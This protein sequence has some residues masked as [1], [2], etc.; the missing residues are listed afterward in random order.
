MTGH[1]RGVWM[2]GASAVT[3]S[4][5]LVL[6]AALLVGCGSSSSSSNG[7]ASKPPAEILAAARAAGVGAA[8]VHVAGSILKAGE[9]ISLDMELVADKGGAGRL[10][11]GGLGLRLVDVDRA[12]YI[13]GSIAFYRHFVGTLA[14]KLLAGKW[15]KGPAASGPLASFAALTDL[16][17]LIDSALGGH[18]ALS[19][20]PSKV[21]DG[22][23]VLGVADRAGGG[24]LYV[25]ATG[26]PYP[27]AIIEVGTHGGTVTFN[28]WNKPVSLAVP[29][30]S[31][32]IHQLRGGR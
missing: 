11:L 23:E 29:A 18:R 1:P 5:A 20:A 19:R 13:K 7:L 28:R 6:L 32:S 10:T 12:V 3:R 26:T 31:I 27:V 14:A 16:R 25:A 4:L 17:T 22:R 30:T 24:T 21:I 8:T 2:P 15:L 9:P